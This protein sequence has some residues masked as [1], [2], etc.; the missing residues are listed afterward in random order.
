MSH[1]QVNK[2]WILITGV[3]NQN[4]YQYFKSDIGVEIDC[5]PAYT[6][7]QYQTEEELAA[8]VDTIEED[9]FYMNPE[10]RIEADTL[11]EE[12]EREMAWE[13]QQNSN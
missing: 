13:A 2:P 10:N 8:A 6:I 12:W 11:E 1:T 3:N 9:G 5:N 7:T 4:G